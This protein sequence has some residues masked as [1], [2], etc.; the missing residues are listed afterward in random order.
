M[1]WAPVYVS[2]E[3]LAAHVRSG[4][5]ADDVSLALAA[6]TAS[7]TIDARCARQFGRTTGP[8]Q[9]FYT[10]RWSRS[11]GAWCAP[12][13]DLMSQAD[14]E[15]AVDSAGDGTYSSPVTAY[16]LRPVNAFGE[17]RPWTE[18]WVRASSPVQPTGARDAVRVTARWGWLGIPDA[19]RKACL[20]QASRLLS[21]RDA[22]FGISGSPETGGELR[23]LAR[24]DPDVVVAV[25]PYRR[26]VWAA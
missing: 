8:E 9:R 16:Q 22:P 23:L 10:A 18:L 11:R 24:L 7:R 26:R 19:I 13:D 3:E 5:A 15:V 6:E 14:L 2:T 1:G 20:L 12:I 25:E 17:G 21:R 4:G